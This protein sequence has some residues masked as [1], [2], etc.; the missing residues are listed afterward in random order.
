MTRVIR[1]EAGAPIPDDA[2]RL[3][4]DAVRS[5]KVVAFPTDT[6]YGLG[7]TG[8]VKAVAHKIYEIKGRDGRK[9]LPILV[10][11]AQAAGRWIQWTPAAAALAER[12]WPG[13]L[14]LALKP[15]KEGEVLSF[16]GHAT[17][18]VRVP[19][20]PVI[21]RCLEDSG[22]PWAST[23]ANPSGAPALR[24]GAD[25]VKHFGDLVDVIID[26]G[27]VPG[28]ESTVVDASQDPV[29]ILREGA[30]GSDEIRAVLS[31]VH[32]PPPTT[33][34]KRFLFICTG[35]TC[36]SL[37]AEKLLAKLSDDRSLSLESRSCGV[38]AERYFEVPKEVYA[39]L[40]GVGIAR[41]DH[42]PQLVSRELLRWADMALAMTDEHLEDVIDRYPEYGGKVH[43]LGRY[44]DLAEPN[45]ED[46][47]GQAEGV[48]AACR[49]KL[50]KAVQA[51]L[52]RSRL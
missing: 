7:S 1:L 41:F 14:T 8:L 24:D 9:P 46:P 2:V 28:K 21:L 13:A 44:A 15:T 17:V 47:I 48:Y 36:R 51:V 16:P 23:S 29:R 39:V 11:S 4:S 18:A 30:I 43:V 38:A 40:G 3:V 20:H 26:A 25:V 5:C 33:P 27:R 50:A 10:A 49:D 32:G 12:W 34:P 37:M 45:V 31:K 35:N 22:V 6:V 19:S 42:V 52:E